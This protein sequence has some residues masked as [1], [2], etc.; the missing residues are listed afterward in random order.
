[1]VL[2]AVGDTHLKKTVFKEH[3]VSQGLWDHTVSDMEPIIGHNDTVGSLIF[4][5]KLP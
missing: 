4:P 2:D 1:M 3:I 5:N